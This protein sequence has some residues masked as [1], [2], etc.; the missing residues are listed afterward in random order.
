[1]STSPPIL[2]V[3]IGN[4][5]SYEVVPGPIFTTLEPE[6][7]AHEMSYEQE[8]PLPVKPTSHGLALIEMESSPASTLIDEP[9][10]HIT[11]HEATPELRDS[12]VEEMTEQ[13]MAGYDLKPVESWL[14]ERLSDSSD[15]EIPSREIPIT[16]HDSPGIPYFLC[17]FIST[18]LF[19]TFM[20]LLL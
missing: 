13:A 14:E 2:L 12:W 15:V 18:S 10:L 9:H 8:Y 4:G 11:D 19:I 6:E 3:P 5:D 1:M 16:I 20:L 17:Y 7:V